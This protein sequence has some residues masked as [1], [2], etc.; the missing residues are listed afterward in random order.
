MKRIICFM[1][2]FIMSVSMLISSASAVTQKKSSFSD[3][4]G[5]KDEWANE[6]IEKMVSQGVISGVGDNKFEPEGTLKRE[7]LAKLVALC[8]DLDSFLDPEATIEKMFEDVIPFSWYE[9]YVILACRA[10]LMKGV[11]ENTF[12]VG[13]GMKKCDLALLMAR[14]EY[15]DEELAAFESK[16]P[17]NAKDKDKIPAYAK[18]AMG[19]CYEK[20]LITGD[21]N[22]DLKPLEFI[23][24]AQITK[25]LCLFMDLFEVTD[26]P[27]KEPS[28]EQ[29]SEPSKEII[30]ENGLLQI[31]GYK[32]YSLNESLN[33]ID[34]STSELSEELQYDI[35]AAIHNYSVINMKDFL[36]K[37]A[38]SSK[39]IF[40]VYFIE[41]AFGK[42]SDGYYVLKMHYPTP[43]NYLT[44]KVSYEIAGEKFISAW[45]DKE[46]FI[47]KDG[48]IEDL[49]KAYEKGKVGIETVK[50]ASQLVMEKY[51]NFKD[52]VTYEAT[53]EITPEL[54]SAEIN[55]R[56][57]KGIVSAET[58]T[59]IKQAMY[60]YYVKYEYDT[61]WEGIF[62]GDE[63]LYL[64]I[65]KFYGYTSD[66]ACIFMDL[67]PTSN[68]ALADAITPY[69]VFDYIVDSPVDYYSLLVYKDGEVN[70]ICTA[71]SKG[72]I[73]DNT[74]KSFYNDLYLK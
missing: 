21:E 69:K 40:L 11:S 55:R 13:E 45:A 16:L 19:Y 67:G 4:I 50:S 18:G 66:G 3:V 29:T 33:K 6:Y 58:E 41:K 43:Y 26:E 25:V 42:T 61:I 39:E 65:H 27:S 36:I 68:W 15:S 9:E 49:S 23:T 52:P 63:S 1:L 73:D 2:A 57:L 64:G 7:E 22:G 34:V 32:F 72:I 31:P 46:I 24:R 70:D 59:Q 54:V 71:Y 53:K 60:R 74:I 56:E 12:G 8:F 17:E 38:D 51:K 20:G 62:N 44:G 37:K 28:K 5:T 10:G 14:F 48:Y 30:D 35:K 47:Y